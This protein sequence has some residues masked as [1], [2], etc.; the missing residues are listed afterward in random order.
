M[1]WEEGDKRMY[2]IILLGGG[3]ERGKMSTFGGATCLR[4]VFRRRTL[5]GWEGGWR[6]SRGVAVVIL[7]HSS[8]NVKVRM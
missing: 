5:G 3:M 8:R 1:G 6:P 4:P 7:H 2:I